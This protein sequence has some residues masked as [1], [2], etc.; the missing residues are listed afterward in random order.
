[1][2]EDPNLRLS[3]NAFDHP[4]VRRKSPERRATRGVE[5]T[6][7]ALWSSFLLHWGQPMSENPLVAILLTKLESQNLLRV[8]P[9]GEEQRKLRNKVA[10]CD[11]ALNF[12]QSGDGPRTF[13]R[14]GAPDR[15]A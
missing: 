14:E 5:K 2:N 11:I 6:S 1:M 10:A 13:R 4:G 8:L 12:L 3:E 9:P 15:A 7:Q